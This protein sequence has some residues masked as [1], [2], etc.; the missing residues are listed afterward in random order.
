[1]GT[2][3]LTAR[4]I[5]NMI[6]EASNGREAE[7]LHS[8]PMD[9]AIRKKATLDRLT[10]ITARKIGSMILDTSND[11]AEVAIH[12]PTDQDRRDLHHH[13][14]RSTEGILPSLAV[15]LLSLVHITVIRSNGQA[16]K[17]KLQSGFSKIQETATES[18][19]ACR[20][21]ET[22]QIEGHFR[23][24][25]MVGL[26]RRCRRQRNRRKVQWKSGRPKRR[27][28]CTRMPTSQR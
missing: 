27:Q 4:K 23:H 15:N 8:N 24:N 18:G 17:L 22:G 28:D 7:D 5:D 2:K 3:K 13:P 9:T 20:M 14:T 10:R 16:T 25:Q 12:L 19:K 6:H 21:A 26:V 1:M 11:Q